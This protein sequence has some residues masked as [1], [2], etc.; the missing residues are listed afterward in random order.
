MVKSDLPNVYLLK[1]SNIA[2]VSHLC[3]SSVLDLVNQHIA[4]RQQETDD[5]VAAIRTRLN[6]LHSEMMDLRDALNE[7]INNTARAEEV[8]DA[9]KKNLEDHQVSL[10]AKDVQNFYYSIWFWFWNRVRSSVYHVVHVQRKIEDLV[11]KQMEVNELI[12]MSEDDV[13]QVNDL[14]S[15]L[16]N[17]KE[18]RTNQLLQLKF[19]KRK[20][21]QND[22]L[23][24]FSG[25]ATFCVLAGL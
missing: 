7:A 12:Q 5:A 10:D 2:A 6:N 13:A 24:V 23:D 11:A 9:N 22:K 17:S 14:L 19:A 3:P 15:V 21:C 18:V 25:Y 8:N 1:R 4:A 20:L 16:Q